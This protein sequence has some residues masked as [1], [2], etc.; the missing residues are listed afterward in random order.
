VLA[1][2]RADRASLPAAT[3]R[4]ERAALVVLALASVW[5]ALAAI[6]EI[7]APFGAGHYAAATAVATGGENVWRWGV[8]GAVPHYTL[9]APQPGDFYC[10]HP[11]GTFW[12]AAL[13]VKLFG[14]H[15]W[16][17]RLPAVLMSA[18]MPP[19]LYAAGRALW[20]P[21]AG[22]AA[23]LG[24]TVVP[25]ALAFANFFALEVPVMFGVAL[26]IWG[27]IRLSQSGR[28]RWLVL[29]LGGLTFAL[30][31]DWAAFVFAAFLLA[32]LFARI[33]VLKRFFPPAPLRRLGTFWAFAACLAVA[34]A[35]FYLIAFASLG[36]L[37]QF[38]RQGQFRTAGAERPL[39]EALLARKTWIETSFTPLAIALGKLAAPVCALRFVLLRREG[40]WLP[41]AVLGMAVV[42]YVLF[43]NG[44]DIHFFWPHYFA[45]YFALALGA[46]TRTLESALSSLTLA[47]RRPRL[48]R[49]APIVALGAAALIALTMAPDGVR[50]LIFARKTGGRFNEKGSIIHPD[51]D[52]AAAFELVAAKMKP[53]QGLLVHS[54]MKVS[55]WMNWA[56][57]RP[58][59][60]ARAPRGNGGERYFML[61]ARFTPPDELAGVL[62]RHSPEL[63]G[64]FW[65][66]DRNGPRGPLQGFRIERVE[67]SAFERFFVSGS[68]ALRRVEPDPWLAWEVADHFLEAPAPAPSTEPSGAEALRAAHNQALAAGD[69]SRARAL[70]ERLL[71]G[72]DQ[73]VRC[74]YSDGSE[75]IGVRFERGASDVLSVYLRAGNPH[76]LERR[77]GIESIVEAPPAWSLVPADP[78]LRDVGMPP[79]IA[80][81][82]WKAGYVY[83]TVTE[84]MKRPGRERFV[85][86]F[87]GLGAPEPEGCSPEQTLLVLED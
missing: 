18:S 22:A 17:C 85:G 63:I 28:R 19:L 38:L 14:H 59:R 35:A 56:L 15:D 52:K 51:I 83:S 33:F 81:T 26:C 86:G 29:A 64:P 9:D 32:A 62:E 11:W 55:Y 78:V 6:W 80:A 7:G 50:A 73:S 57:Q 42:Q 3:P 40:E 8:L 76:A 67:P 39:A 79:V 69:E 61:D 24:F 47:L 72:S 68:H 30:H 41:L 4:G 66:V 44:A 75:L 12:T 31:A 82:R 34:S 84:V 20:S 87:R 71:R 16:V 74:R 77:F 65:F 37:E 2:L 48:G 23:A 10:H 70:L 27:T 36:Q 25:I 1:W 13:F 49:A 5:F 43:K 45:L 60:V 54:G 58:L 21:V 46:L 53:D